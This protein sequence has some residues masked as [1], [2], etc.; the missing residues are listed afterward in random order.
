MN[1]YIV[2]GT[3]YNLIRQVLFA[4]RSFSNNKVVVIGGPNTRRLAWSR[5]C[6]RHAEATFDPGGDE[7]FV[8]L[9][10]NLA[11]N[12]RNAVL[13]PADCEGARTI[14]RVRDRLDVRIIPIAESATLDMFDDKWR[15][16]QF[17]E[18]Q[19]LRAPQTMYVGSKTDLRFA[20]VAGRLGTPFVVKPIN[21]AGS[22]GV[23]VI[24][25]EAQYDEAILHNNAYQYFPLVAQKFVDGDD[26]CIDLFALDGQVRALAFQQRVG[27]EIRF[28]RN[29]E[30]ESLAHRLA[31]VSAYNGV[32]NLDARIEKGTGKVFLLES[33]PRFWASL[34]AS[35]GCGLNFVSESLAPA[36]LSAPV[37]MLT[38]GTFH[39]RHPIAR[40]SSWMRVIADTGAHGRLQRARMS[41]MELL[42][43]FAKSVSGRLRISGRSVQP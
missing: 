7:H 18:Q 9:V 40:P 38:C 4:I 5:L 28:F 33:N 42:R 11:K 3:C 19:K 2:V 25:T 8:G 22:N 14:N 41:D 23:Q 21:Q 39:L 30:M 13:I 15:F 43:D 27:S 32:M 35:V 20:D 37:R 24:Q 26:V 31:G 1:N 34:T 6:A 29:D 16:F 36:P 12:L 17:C 10:E